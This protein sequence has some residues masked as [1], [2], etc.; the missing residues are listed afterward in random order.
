MVIS[1][2]FPSNKLCVDL[3]G[4]KTHSKY[5]PKYNTLFKPFSLNPP[6]QKVYIMHNKV[7]MIANLLDIFCMTGYNHL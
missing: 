7:M 2:K 3:I 1:E 4:P 6:S 5:R